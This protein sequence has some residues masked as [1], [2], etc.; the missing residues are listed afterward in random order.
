M[1]GFGL[2]LPSDLLPPGPPARPWT[3]SRCPAHPCEHASQ[4]VALTSVDPVVSRRPA[5]GLASPPAPGVGQ[6]GRFQDQCPQERQSCVTFRD[7][8]SEAPQHQ[9]C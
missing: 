8:A 5:L 2:H 9:R 1:S 6:A 3:T 4:T 7:P